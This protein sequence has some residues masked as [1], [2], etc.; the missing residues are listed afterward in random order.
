MR[1]PIP[2]LR[3][4][5]IATLLT[6]GSGRAQEPQPQPPRCDAAEFRQFD[7]WLG[8]WRV[9]GPDGR[10]LG[11]NRITSVLDG[12]VLLEEWTGAAGGTGKS[13]NAYDRA[14]GV[15]RQT[16]V[17]NSGGRLDL[18]GGL[19]GSRMVLSNEATGPDGRTIR[20]RLSFEPSGGGVR[21]HWERSN[22]GGAT[23]TTVF[24]GL[25]TPSGRKD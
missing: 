19:D 16:W 17:D 4:A 13:F 10:V 6:P 22:D 23:W 18:S 20:Q 2:F 1:P 5:L 11:H 12:C 25:Y 14:A 24:D 7:F 21:Q 9:T 3:T 15:W 8:D